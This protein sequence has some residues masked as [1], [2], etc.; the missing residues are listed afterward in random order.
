[1]FTG[2]VQAMGR[3]TGVESTGVG[4]R[5]TIDP[6]DW[7]HRPALGDSISVDGCCLTVAWLDNDRSRAIAFDVVPETLRKTTFDAV[8]VGAMVNL[9]PSC[10]A[11]TLLGGHIVQGHVEGVAEV[12]AARR[13]PDEWRV[14]LRPPAD[15]MECIAPKGSIAVAGVSLTIADTGPDWFEVALIPTTL[16]LTN[17]AKLDTGSRC[18]IE[19]DIIARSV[20]NWLRRQKT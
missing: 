7:P 9:E 2:L 11:A 12:V 17:L 14:R 13:E 3:V 1:M 18:N 19:T 15:L 4:T 16:R 5:L 8:A 10:T 6:G 20:V